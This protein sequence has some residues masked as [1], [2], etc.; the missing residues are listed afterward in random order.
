MLNLERTAIRIHP[1]SQTV[2]KLTNVTLSC[3]ATTDVNEF[4]SLKLSWLYNRQPISS[5]DQRYVTVTISAT[6]TILTLTGV[7][8]EQAGFYQCL[9]N[10]SLDTALSQVAQLHI[11]GN[12]TH[13]NHP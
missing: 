3:E 5:L 1:L 9:A 8:R 12:Y 11:K 13:F 7:R 4:P 10:N 2:H 6:R